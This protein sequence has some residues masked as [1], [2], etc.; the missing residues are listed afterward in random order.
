MQGKFTRS[1]LKE[2]K[3]KIIA[4]THIAMSLS[5]D[6]ELADIFR[7]SGASLCAGIDSILDNLDEGHSL[8]Y[9]IVEEN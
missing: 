1:D 4:V 9:I 5:E 7:T 8:N 2:L 3:L 6:N